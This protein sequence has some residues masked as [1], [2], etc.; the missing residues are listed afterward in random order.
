MDAQT[1]IAQAT[2]EYEKAQASFEMAK[3]FES[4]ERKLYDLALDAYRDCLNTCADFPGV[5]ENIKDLE[6][7]D[8]EY[9]KGEQL[10]RDKKLV[11]AETAFLAVARIRSDYANV[12]DYLVKIG[13]V[14]YEVKNNYNKGVEQQNKKE[15]AKALDYYNKVLELISEYKDTTKR[16]VECQ[17]QLGVRS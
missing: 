17:Q 1:L 14:L 15:W 3:R 8:A 11:D 10:Y 9:K 4:N 2:K 6:T 13:D 12:K 16:L 7:V 5:A